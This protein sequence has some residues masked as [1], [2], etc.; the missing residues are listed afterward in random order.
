MNRKK[1]S[2]YISNHNT[3]M[4][5]GVNGNILDD[6]FPTGPIRY[7]LMNDYIFKAVLQKN[8]KAL[9]GLLAALLKLSVNDIRDIQ[10][11]NPIELGEAVDDKTCILD[12][13]LM[14]NNN[15]M[16]NIEL[17]VA[18]FKD[19]AERSLLYLCRMFNNLHEGKD[20][21]ELIPAYHIG[22]LDF[23]LPEKTKELYSEYRLMNVRNQELYS[24]KFGI[25]VLNLKA[26]DNDSVTRESDELYEW[27]K[28]FKATTWEEIKMLADKNE[29]IADTVVTL[30]Q[31][32]DDEKIRMQAEARW[33]YEHDRVS[34][35]NQGK[36][37]GEAIGEVRGEER[38]KEK[39]K[40][41]NIRKLAEYY[42]K[43]D[44]SLTEE[45][46][47]EKAKEILN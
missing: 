33:R 19:W 31:L 24:G 3:I 47:V 30:R 17:Q 22:I 5:E 18:Y 37:E 27:A 32:T 6:D 46:A 43:Q 25:N 42:M 2:A 9:K 10:I 28:L 14:L 16:I 23:W 7:T 15:K 8:E 45:K 39:E 26:V 20:Y 1:N 11:M 12:I 44:S 38:G 4:T 36:E 35:Y 21:G 29:Y 41:A 13:K 34:L 40:A